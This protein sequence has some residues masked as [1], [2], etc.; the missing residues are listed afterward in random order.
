MDSPS[1]RPEVTLR[2]AQSLEDAD[3]VRRLRNAGRLWF[4]DVRPVDPSA[5]IRWWR[6]Q[7]DSEGFLC[8]LA[9]EPPVGYGMLLRRADGRRWVSLA[10][11]PESRGQGIGTTIY[12]ALRA[13]AAPGDPIYA[14]IRSDNE[15]SRAAAQRA[16][17][18]LV[19]TI[20]AP[21]PDAASWI[22]MEATRPEEEDQ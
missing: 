12:A 21:V 18:R 14:G 15:P 7:I 5:Q 10:V 13:L 2:L 3:I 19:E 6:G 11:D 1:S 17:F 16:G 20:R 8:L 9:G 22:V 4:S